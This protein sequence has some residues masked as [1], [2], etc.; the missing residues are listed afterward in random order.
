MSDPLPDEVPPWER[1]PLP[2]EPG[3]EDNP[4]PPPPLPPGWEEE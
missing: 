2:G 1:D 3:S 4:F